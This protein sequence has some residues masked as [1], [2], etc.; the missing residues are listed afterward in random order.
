MRSPFASRSVKLHYARGALG[1]VALVA[2]VAG[3]AAGAPVA[4]ALL[5][6]TVAAWRGCP[7]CWAIG[8]MQTRECEAC[9]SQAA[10]GSH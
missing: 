10:S 2:A 7:T 5:I 3:A 6:V 9:A 4:L 1:L 8:L